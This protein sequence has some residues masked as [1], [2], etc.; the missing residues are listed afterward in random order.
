MAQAIARVFGR[1]GEKKNR[2]RARMKFLIKN[3][4]MEKFRE[5]VLAE[6]AALPEDPRWEEYLDGAELEQEGPLRPAGVLPDGPESESYRR[7]VETNIREQRQAGYVTATVTL[8][9]GDISASQLRAVAAAARRF[10]RGTVRTT[11]EQ[12][13]VLRWVSKADVP[14]LFEALERAGLG[15]AM[16]GNILDI[17]ACPGTDT[18]KLG[19]ASSRGLAGELRRRLEEKSYQMDEVVRGLHIKVSGCFNSCGQH[20]VADIGFYGVSRNK[21]GFQVPHFQVVLGGQWEEN[22]ASFGLPILAVPSRRIPDA[23]DRLTE[24]YLR[25]R[26]DDENFPQ[27]VRRVGKVALHRLLTD[28]TESVPAHDEDASFYSDWGDPRQYGTGDIG[29]GECAGEVVSAFEFDVA[30]AERMV[31]EAQVKL[32]ADDVDAAGRQAVAA[33]VQAAKGLVHVQME[34]VPQEPARILEE[35]RVRFYETRLVFDPYAKGKF[36][37]YLFA[38]VGRNGSPFS[39]EEAHHTIEE[40]QLFIESVHRC[41]NRMLEEAAQPATGTAR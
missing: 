35:F 5:E 19:I 14:A 6:R 41:Y 12:N 33:M 15:G 23:V 13:I 37:N 32:E 1:H 25:D 28:L 7:W 26:V 4:G 17:V 21:N 31:F 16:A 18:C 10:T 39:A 36:A 22:A 2:N 30:A 38:A 40:A 3:W 24:A 27:F 29:K 11:V 34:D 9:L 8:P 20:H